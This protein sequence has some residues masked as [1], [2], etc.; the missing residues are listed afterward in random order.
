MAVDWGMAAV[1]AALAIFVFPYVFKKLLQ[2]V[3]FG[4]AKSRQCIR[5]K[6]KDDIPVGRVH[7]CARS[8][9]RYLCYHKIH[10]E[11][12]SRCWQSESSLGCVF[13]RA[14]KLS[15]K[16]P[17]YVN[18]IPSDLPHSSPFLCTDARTILA[19]ILCTIN[20]EKGK[21]HE[22]W[23][24]E[25]LTYGPTQIIRE[26]IGN[27]HVAHIKGQVRNERRFLT[28][29]EL[30]CML[31]GYPPW[32]RESFKTR[33]GLKVQFPITSDKDITRAGWILAVGLMDNS[34]EGQKPLALYRCSNEPK[35]PGFRQNGG[36]FR[37]A[38]ARCRD[39]I[40]KNIQPHFPDNPNA[41]AAIESLNYLVNERTGSGMPTRSDFSEYW[42]SNIPHLRSSDCTFV[43]ANF[44]A[45]SKLEDEDKVR[46]G[47]QDPARTSAIRP[48]DLAKGLYH[49]AADKIRVFEE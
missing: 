13:D 2:V 21:A 5:F 17:Y 37:Q 11:R 48:G 41:L 31:D 4:R 22:E 10:H 16:R 38:V 47:T 8:T 23:H 18:N 19:F 25:S 20:D 28:K 35:E 29:H 33:N 36:E 26:K 42:T 7:D 14:W 40:V 27:I 34:I 6:W 46:N 12:G 44:N 1:Y 43:C 24:Q 30:G 39:H 9:G 3:G 15:E 49:A 32:Y 45:Y